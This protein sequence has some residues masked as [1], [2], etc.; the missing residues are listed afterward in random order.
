M[1]YKVL[2]YRVLSGNRIFGLFRTKIVFRDFHG[3]YEHVKYD[4]VNLRPSPALPVSEGVVM[5][6]ITVGGNGDA[7]RIQKRP[8]PLLPVREGRGGSFLYLFFISL[9]VSAPPQ[10]R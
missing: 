10:S 2:Y 6:D 5:Q 3:K 7:V 1:Q 8:T 9:R 4:G